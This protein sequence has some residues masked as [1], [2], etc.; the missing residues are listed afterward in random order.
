MDAVKRNPRWNIASAVL[1]PVAILAAIAALI[2]TSEP[3]SLGALV[4]AVP[5]YVLFSLF[6]AVAG[7][8]AVIRRERFPMLS[9]I[10]LTINAIPC[11]WVIYIILREVLFR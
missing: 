5:T 8:V 10:A 4:Y 9:W 7:V 6:G 2:I 1:Q 11:L 3:Q